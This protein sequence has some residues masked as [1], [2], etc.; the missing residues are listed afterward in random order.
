MNIEERFR[1]F[2]KNNPHVYQEF[3]LNS[4]SIWRAQRRKC[5]N[6]LYFSQDINNHEI[7]Y[8]WIASL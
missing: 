3:E 8:N 2:H 6:I 4:E 5:V 1:E 7:D